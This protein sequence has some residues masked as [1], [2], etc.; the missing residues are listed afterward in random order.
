[1]SYIK[2]KSDKLMLTWPECL[3]HPLQDEEAGTKEEAL[4]IGRGVTDRKSG[5]GEEKSFAQIV[6][7]GFG[8]GGGG[9]DG[10]S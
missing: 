9:G 5:D 4:V 1:M 7:G 2:K 6:S 10:A 3:L 8:G